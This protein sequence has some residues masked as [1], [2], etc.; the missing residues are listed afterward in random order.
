MVIE[1]LPFS[2]ENEIMG[3]VYFYYNKKNICQLRKKCIRSSRVKLLK[4]KKNFIYDVWMW[5]IQNSN[6]IDKKTDIL[7]WLCEPKKKQRK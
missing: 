7:R 3:K 1:L 5:T 4:K 2:K 6:I